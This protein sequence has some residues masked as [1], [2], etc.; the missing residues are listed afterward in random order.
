[1]LAVVSRAAAHSADTLF[2]AVPQEGR[3]R[4]LGSCPSVPIGDL[5]GAETGCFPSS[6]PCNSNSET[7]SPRPAEPVGA[8]EGVGASLRATTGLLSQTWPSGPRFPSQHTDT[9]R[10]TP[11]ASLSVAAPTSPQDIFPG[12][13]QGASVLGPT[14]SHSTPLCLLGDGAASPKSPTYHVSSVPLVLV[15]GL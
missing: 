9:L 10:H 14:L 1:M 13:H 7:S 3:P 11:P 4:W 12:P 6:R 8:L 5:G 15:W 2:A